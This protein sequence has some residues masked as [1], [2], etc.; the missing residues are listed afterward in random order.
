MEKNRELL[1]SLKQLQSDKEVA[2]VK[3]KEAEK[4]NKRS[5]KNIRMTDFGA[6]ALS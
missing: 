5:E 1:A 2:T 3:G 6:Q 4:G